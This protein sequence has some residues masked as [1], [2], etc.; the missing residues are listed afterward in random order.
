MFYAGL[1]LG[2]L[3]GGIVGLIIGGLASYAV[4]RWLVQSVVDVP[5]RDEWRGI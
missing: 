5:C 2:L 4:C 1:S 3:I